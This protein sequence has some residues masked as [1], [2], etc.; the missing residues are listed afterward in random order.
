MLYHIQ[1]LGGVDDETSLG[2]IA[3]EEAI[4]RAKQAVSDSSDTE[5][6][7]EAEP[8][9][10]AATAVELI[11]PV[12]VGLIDRG[13]WSDCP[14]CGSSFSSFGAAILTLFQTRVAGDSCGLV[15]VPVIEEA[16]A[17]CLIFGAALFTIA[18]GLPLLIV[19]DVVDR[20]A[21]VR[22]RNLLSR[23]LDVEEVELSRSAR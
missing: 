19:R 10:W 16:P 17:T 9:G 1:A 12:V 15:A 14:R 13:V 6:D 8:L 22:E 18:Y 11:H 4:A 3:V 23:V 2:R 7:S 21:E 20:F 5:V